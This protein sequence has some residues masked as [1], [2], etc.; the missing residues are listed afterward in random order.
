L[1]SSLNAKLIGTGISTPNIRPVY[2]IGMLNPTPADSTGPSGDWE[3][4]IHPSP[5]GYSKLGITFEK[6]ITLV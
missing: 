6:Q 3:N 5:Q 4:E 2:L 1:L